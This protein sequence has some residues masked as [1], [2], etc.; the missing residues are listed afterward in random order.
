MGMR[1]EQNMVMDNH[2]ITKLQQ[3]NKP[4]DDKDELK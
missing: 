2:Q 1:E 3:N 4:S